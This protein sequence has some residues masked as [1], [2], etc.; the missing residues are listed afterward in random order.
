LVLNRYNSNIAAGC[1]LPDLV[2][3]LKGSV[4]TFDEIHENPELVYKYS[5]TNNSKGLDLALG[6]MTHS[7]KFGADKFNKDID[8]WL[9]GDNE[10]LKTKIAEK[11]CKA[12]NVSMEVARG[13]RMHNY[14]WCG[15]DFFILDKYPDFTFEMNKAYKEVNSSEISKTLSEVFNKPY[16]LIKIDVDKHIGLVVRDDIKDK[17]SFIRFWKDFISDL[18]DKD[19]INIEAAS[20]VIGYIEDLFYKDWDEIIQKVVWS[21]KDRMKECIN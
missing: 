4:L 13:P 14:L 12:S 1:H 2:P 6:L 15:L 20:E 18:P 10:D 11:V 19:D 5:L 21:I 17:D 3:F 7:V 16:D 9:L 8:A